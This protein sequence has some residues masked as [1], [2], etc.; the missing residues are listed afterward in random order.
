MAMAE[1]EQDSA[2]SGQGD[3]GRMDDGDGMDPAAAM[4][5]TWRQTGWRQHQR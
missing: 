4:A 5:T 1:E 2:V 3:E